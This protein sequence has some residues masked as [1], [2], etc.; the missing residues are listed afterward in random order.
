MGM[1][2]SHTLVSGYLFGA[3]KPYHASILF[4]LIVPQVFFQLKYLLKD[5]VKYDV[6]YQASAQP[7]MVLGLLVTALATS[8]H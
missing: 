1:N 2:I 3:G 7:F 5:P 6:I 4:A 8:T